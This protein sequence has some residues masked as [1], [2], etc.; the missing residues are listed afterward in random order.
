M[1]RLNFLLLLV[2][3]QVI[4]FIVSGCS[5]STPE[6]NA[7]KVK[8][9]LQ[10]LSKESND[11]CNKEEYKRFFIKSPCFANDIT[12]EQLSDKTM[13]QDT[14]KDAF[15]KYREEVSAI[16]KKFSDISQTYGDSKDKEFGL[17]LE[18]NSIK[19][20]RKASL[21]FVEGKISWGEFNKSRK[22]IAQEGE[23]ERIRIYGK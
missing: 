11:F 14:E 17:F 15:L 8:E 20:K 18:K 22:E 2:A 6:K 23:K 21:D 7:A 3:L 1:K 10:S 12:A 9:M 13:I 5:N 4:L 16:D 19:S